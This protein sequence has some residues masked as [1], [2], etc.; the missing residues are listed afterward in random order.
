MATEELYNKKL[1]VEGNDDKHVFLALCQQ[2]NVFENFDVVDCK[3]ANFLLR[4]F[5][6]RLRQ[7]DIE[8]IG[9][10][11]DAD[12]DLNAKWQGISATLTL[13]GFIVPAYIPANGLTLAHPLSGI[14]I[15]VWIMPNNNV[16]GML[17]DFMRFLIPENDALLPIANDALAGIENRNFNK[18]SLA[19]RSKALIHT[20]L[21]WQ[22]EAGKPLGQSITMRYFNTDN[23]TCLKLINWLNDTFSD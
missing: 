14:K 13:S 23:E 6:E 20:W 15:G 22:E 4:Q 18:Y 1:L 11:I 16:N 19:H 7:S 2:Y 5:P 12:T 21:A 3:G 8:T 17:E 9:V 10:V